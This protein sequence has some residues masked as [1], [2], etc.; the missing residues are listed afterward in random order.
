MKNLFSLFLIATLCFPVLSAQQTE[1][2]ELQPKDADDA[3]I[4]IPEAAEP[5]P[6]E[7]AAEPTT[8]K[9][10]LPVDMTFDVELM[11][12][13]NAK[14]NAP[15][16]RIQFRVAKDVLVGDHVAIS[17]GTYVTGRFISAK[18]NKRGGKGGSIDFQVEETRA[19][20]G[21]VV[22]LEGLI[23]ELGKQK[24]GTAAGIMFGVGGSGFKK[25]G[26]GFA[27][28]GAPYQ[29]TVH[30]DTVITLEDKAQEAESD[31]EGEEIAEAD[32]ECA[33][34]EIYLNLGKETPLSPM[35]VTL[36]PGDRNPETIKRTVLY[37]VND[38]ILD[39][40]RPVLAKGQEEQ[41]DGSLAL[42]FDGWD[43]LR[44]LPNGPSTLVFRSE[45]TGGEIFQG[46]DSVTLD[47]KAKK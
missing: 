33:E 6:Q 41:E 7:E 34:K 15:D 2:T 16:Q 20:D 22:P 19:V 11:E 26:Q 3:P 24:S 8:I 36:K 28:K 18:T 10:T 12:H 42:Q 4:V 9:I 43:V 21:T 32:F 27:Q 17:K 46:S 25:G 37:Q 44:F 1:E 14:Y 47:L 31:E 35:I 38:Y 5:S 23:R 30:N 45:A 29:A 39:P 40:S 13:L